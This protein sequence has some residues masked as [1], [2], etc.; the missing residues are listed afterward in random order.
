MPPV[1]RSI[2]GI[3]RVAKWAVFGE[4]GGNFGN[5]DNSPTGSYNWRQ[6]AYT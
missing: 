2:E 6:Y 4:M 3:K 1:I 5:S